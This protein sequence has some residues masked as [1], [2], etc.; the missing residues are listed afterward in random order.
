MRR[1]I[2]SA[3]TRLGRFRQLPAP[4][5]D[6]ACY[7]A[8]VATA[9]GL[10][11]ALLPVMTGAL[12][13]AE[14][15]RLELLLAL[16]EIAGLLLGAGLVDTLY[17]FSALEGRRGVARVVGL[18]LVLGGLGLLAALLAA[19]LGA[20][21]PLPAAS[22]EVML[23]GAAVALDAML[24]VPLATLRV[25]GRAG[26][27]AAVVVARGALHVGAAWLLLSLGFGVAG[28]LGA[29]ALAA[30][31]VAALLLAGRAR[32]GEVALEPASWGRLLGYGAPLILGG[33]A[34]FALGAADRWFLAAHVPGAALAEYALAV[35]LAMAAAFLTQ[36]FELW[37]YP[38][39][40]ALLAQP[41]GGARTVRLVGLGGALVLLAAGAAAVAGPALI[42]WATPADYHGAAAWVPWLA[43]ALALQSLGSLVNVGCYAGRTTTQALAVNGGAGALALAG[44]ALLV[45]AHGVAGAVA[46]TL[47]AQALR[48]VAF[49]RLSARSH[50][51]PYPLGRLALLALPVAGTAALA[52]L[53]GS[54]AV[55]LLAALLA[56]AG[57]ALLAALL[58]LLPLPRLAPAGEPRHA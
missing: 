33:L 26:A 9:K 21:L 34:A 38:R 16:G 25:D 54:G 35:K 29:A 31:A 1:H 6:A 14:F 23:L 18:G 13:P 49:H 8:A 30:A 17:R 53:L 44:Y 56:L 2:A 12:A 27:Y 45:P 51:L 7:G 39:R 46:A 20:L 43:A 11:L 41:D 19:P 52:Q 24:G 10:G 48:L 15:A 28:V 5:R 32:V 40:I 50:A 37:W 47:A 4:L 22:A 3:Y 36:P 57:S 42:R 58:G 55:G